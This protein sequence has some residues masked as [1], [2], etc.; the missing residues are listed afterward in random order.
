MDLLGYILSIRDCMSESNQVQAMQ[1]NLEMMVSNNS[2]DFA[3]CLIR[4]MNKFNLISISSR[5]FNLHCGEAP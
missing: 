5:F 1:D 3:E 2:V 4:K